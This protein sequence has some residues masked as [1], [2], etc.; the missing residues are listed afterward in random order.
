MEESTAQQKRIA[1]IIYIGSK[2][3]WN[4]GKLVLSCFSKSPLKWPYYNVWSQTKPKFWAS[5]GYTSHKLKYLISCSK[6]VFLEE[7]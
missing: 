6:L 2:N 4:W 5:Q 1:K 7:N 3:E